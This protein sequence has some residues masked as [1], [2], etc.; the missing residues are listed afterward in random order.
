MMGRKSK[1]LCMVMIDMEEL[2]PQNHL[3]RKVKTTIDFDLS[4]PLTFWA[5]LP[6]I[7]PGF[8]QSMMAPASACLYSDCLNKPFKV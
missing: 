3:L 5:F 4:E 7:L 8:R 6:C 1:Q 2:I